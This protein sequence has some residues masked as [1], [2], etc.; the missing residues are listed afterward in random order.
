[1][2]TATL[3]GNVT[4]N[5]LATDAWFEWGTDPALSSFAS[6]SSQAIGSGT[7]SQ[8]LSAGL[9][10]FSAGTTY[11]YRVAA[12]NGSGTSK[13]SILSFV[14]G[15]APAV[16]TLAATSVGLSAATLNGNVTPN[17]LATNAW[18]EWGT[19]PTLSTFSST[20][21]QGVG[22][23]TT[24]QSA[25]A[26]LTGLS[27]GITYYFRVA[28]SNGSG[29][30]RGSIM[31]FVPGA[32]PAVTTLAATSV[33]MS[34]ATL[35][36]N[37]TPNGL[38]TNAWF[39]WGT[40]SAL[41]T[42]SSTSS[43][44]IGSGTASQP[45]SDDLTG[46]SGGTTF[47]F[48]VTAQNA[49]GTQKGVIKGFSTTSGTSAPIP[50]TLA[51]ILVTTGAICKGKVNPNGFPSTA[52]F[53]WGTDPALSTYSSSTSDSIGSGT[54]NK[55][56]IE[57]L[58][59]LS[60]GTTYY[61]RVAGANLVGTTRGTIE[62]FTAGIGTWAFYDD[63][64]TDTTGAY[65]VTNSLETESFT[66]DSPGKRARVATG[67]GGNL[68]IS[69]VFLGARGSTGAFS[70]VFSP[71]KEYGSGGNI[72][73]RIMDSPRTYYELSTADARIVKSRA[74]VIVDSVPFPYTYS[75]GGNYTI[76]IT[77]NPDVTT[78]EA[79]GGRASLTLNPGFNPAN[80]FEVWSTSQDASY[81]NIKLA[82]PQ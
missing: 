38:A 76:K 27:A 82:I 49:S 77:F 10:G 30:N 26:G 52:W 65:T 48:R 66:Y 70:M 32:A 45:V 13:G 73:I 1:L 7:T 53:E 9:T 33:G 41:S 80:Y 47:Y 63:F 28:A 56:M 60:A 55:Y 11:Y 69:Q 46:L 16:T 6:T 39:E 43:Q 21:F 31:S 3:N 34:T 71:T 50:T 25:S 14:P 44:A 4:P 64:S 75:Q 19:D 35:N 57:P 58:T 59:G 62:S 5:G 51:P 29:T 37:V 17:G 74:G 67:D 36:G 81:D 61:C 40:N 8:L 22:S 54:S 78:V 24:S 68:L 72:K 18:F 12:S 23:G 2:S 15:A 79:F 42:Y 20:S